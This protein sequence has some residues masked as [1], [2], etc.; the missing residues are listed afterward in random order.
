[1]VM[2]LASLLNL[3]HAVT[4][5]YDQLHA[6]IT[7]QELS[8]ESTQDKILALIR[9][10]QEGRYQLANLSETGFEI[11]RRAGELASELT[12]L[13]RMRD[14]KRE[15]RQAITELMKQT[16]DASTKKALRRE[17]AELGTILEDLDNELGSLRSV[18]DNY[19]A[20]RVELSERIEALEIKLGELE[21]EFKPVQSSL[22]SFEDK[23]AELEL[24]WL[25]Q[26]IANK[27]AHESLE[28]D[29]G[30]AVA[31]LLKAGT[32]LLV[33]YREG[34]GL[35]RRDFQRIELPPLVSELQIWGVAE[36]HEPVL[37]ILEQWPNEESWVETYHGFRFGVGRAIRERRVLEADVRLEELIALEGPIGA[38]SRA[39]F[40]VGRASQSERRIALTE[41]LRLE[42]K[43]A[44]SQPLDEARLI[45]GS[46]EKL[47]QLWVRAHSKE[48]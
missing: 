23:C 46:S 36:A 21:R 43:Y 48:A 37:A 18:Q 40:A 26:L 13:M 27:L 34:R 47:Y 10:L 14:L 42:G 3:L 24:K 38:M 7:G 22:V 12:E 28:G 32:K 2:S 30:Q 17:R 11:D 1:M 9:S 15:R 16:D 44:R 35:F 4:E 25:G 19:R 39:L 31:Q 8:V 33:D 5:E 41:W 45:S 6:V 20:K 29:L